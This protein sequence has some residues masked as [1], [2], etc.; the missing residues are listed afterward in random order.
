[1]YTGNEVENN[2]GCEIVLPPTNWSNPTFLHFCRLGYGLMWGFLTS[3]DF[4]GVFF[5]SLFLNLKVDETR[6]K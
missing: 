6:V 5:V 2:P 1:M 4:L 3:L